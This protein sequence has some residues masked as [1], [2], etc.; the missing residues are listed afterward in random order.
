MNCFWRGLSPLSQSGRDHFFQDN[1]W[2]KCECANAPPSAHQPVSQL[3][4]MPSSIFLLPFKSTR[5]EGAGW[6]KTANKCLSERGKK[7]VKKNSFLFIQNQQLFCSSLKNN[8]WPSLKQLHQFLAFH[9]WRIIHY[10]L[11]SPS[12]SHPFFRVQPKSWA[13]RRWTC[14]SPS[15][16]PPSP[17]ASGRR[18]RNTLKASPRAPLASAALM[19]EMRWYVTLWLW[20]VDDRRLND[21][22]K[23]SINSPDLIHLQNFFL[24]LWNHLLNLIKLIN[25]P[26]IVLKVPW[27]AKVT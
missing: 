24:A 17:S 25:P 26:V 21:G 10:P 3:Q 15:A 18:R 22:L 23:I 13:T 4:S 20:S 2:R 14:A 11:P 6:L 9:S 7:K 5:W 27:H 8:G 16:L 1:D 12:L 19:L